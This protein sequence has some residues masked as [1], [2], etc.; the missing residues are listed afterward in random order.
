M[1]KKFEYSERKGLPG[2]PNETFSYTTGVF[3]TEGYKRYSPDVNNP[4]NII[5]SGNI[6]MR[7]VDFPVEGTDNLGNSIMMKPC[8]DYKFP[9][10]MVF[11][12]PIKE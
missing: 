12:R 9:G 10:N 11:E 5:P 1:K 3:S 7:D 4:F 6:T 8:Y 2:G